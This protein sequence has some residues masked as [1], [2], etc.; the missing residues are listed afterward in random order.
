MKKQIILIT[1]TI[2]IAIIA[3]GSNSAMPGMPGMGRSSSGA[4][5]E[6][7][8]VTKSDRSDWQTAMEH[9]MSDLQIQVKELRRV[10][11]DL[12]QKTEKLTTRIGV[13]QKKLADVNGR[14]VGEPADN[15]D[16]NDE[17]IPAK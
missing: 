3:Q 9:R 13:L 15:N 10:T 12:A 7:D 5:H 4:H 11:H 1:S 17:N 8:T 2:F 14:P 16:A 6:A